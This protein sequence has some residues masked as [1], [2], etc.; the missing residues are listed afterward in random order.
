MQRPP[1][2]H[3]L[4]KFMWIVRGHFGEAQ[5]VGVRRRAPSGRIATAESDAQRETA[6]VVEAHFVEAECALAFEAQGRCSVH[7]A[8]FIGRERRMTARQTQLTQA[9][10]AAQS[11]RE[12]QRRDLDPQSS[13]ETCRRF[14]EARVSVAQ[15][16]REDVAASGRAARIE[17]AANI[18]FE[19]ELFFERHEIY[20]ASLE[21]RAL[22]FER[23]TRGREIVQAFFEWTGGR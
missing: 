1:R 10:A 2:V 5:H 20:Q 22:A 3:G 6:F 23:R 7:R 21:H 18:G 15:D 8:Q 11:N 9:I 19:R 13:A 12:R 14:V 17:A 4:P 16:A